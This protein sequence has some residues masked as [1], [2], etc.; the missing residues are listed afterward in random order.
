MREILVLCIS[1]TKKRLNFFQAISASKIDV[2]QTYLNC[3]TLPS[4][5]S[6]LYEWQIILKQPKI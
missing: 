4:D 2:N 5:I 6:K 3:K 1:A